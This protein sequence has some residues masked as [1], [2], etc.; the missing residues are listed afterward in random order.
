[1]QLRRLIFVGI[2]LLY[3]LCNT[4]Y[5]ANQ[6]IVP[7]SIASNQEVQVMKWYPT[8]NIE[9]L[10]T[11]KRSNSDGKFHGDFIIEVFREKENKLIKL[12]ENEPGGRPYSIFPL[13]NPG[14]S[15]LVTV[16]EKGS[17]YDVTVYDYSKDAI[18]AIFIAGSKLLPEVIH[19]YDENN[20][21]GGDRLIVID[22]NGCDEMHNGKLVR[23]PVIAEVFER[24]RT[25]YNS[26]TVLWKDRFSPHL[27]KVD[28]EY[29]CP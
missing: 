18:K 22:A 6:K 17:G 11:F 9:L 24:T 10:C 26:L 27:N 28:Q 5:S 2:Y 14:N 13:G 8:P 1:M 12:F 19:I 4:G 20:Q 7:E 21:I 3:C 25:S 15:K 16:W 29:T 23:V